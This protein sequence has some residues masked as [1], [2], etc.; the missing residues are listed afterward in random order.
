MLNRMIAIELHKHLQQTIPFQ[1]TITDEKGVILTGTDHPGPG[2]FLQ[3]AWDTI[4]KSPSEVCFTSVGDYYGIP[5]TA[6]V[7]LVLKNRVEGILMMEGKKEELAPYVTLAA[8][9]SEIILEYEFRQVKTQRYR[10]QKDLFINELLYEENVGRLELIKN[11]ERLNFRANVIRVPVIFVF[12]ERVN[13]EEML[14]VLLNKVSHSIQDIYMLTRN[15][16]IFYFKELENN[17]MILAEYKSVIIEFFHDFFLYLEEN[18]VPYRVI[19]GTFQ[20]NLMYYRNS[21]THCLWLENAY[22]K[23]QKI[24]FFYDYITQYFQSI[25]PLKEYHSLFNVFR[26]IF[27]EEFVESYVKIMPVLSECNYN[28]GEASK[29]LFVHKNTLVLQFNKIREA[30]GINPLQTAQDRSVADL[31]CYYL[32]AKE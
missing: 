4:K 2:T 29:E 9:M 5:E 11:A 13:S 19:V 7:P 18:Q 21:I 20:N 30:M 12:E 28:L 26:D 17:T 6:L 16:K 1:L 27:S 10:S 15:N 3:A 32:N 8:K 23:K 14:A 31:L 24:L 22:R 25:I